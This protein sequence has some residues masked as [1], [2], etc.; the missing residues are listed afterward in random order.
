MQQCEEDIPV[1]KE[2]KSDLQE[3]SHEEGLSTKRRAIS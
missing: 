3:L 1:H 2:A